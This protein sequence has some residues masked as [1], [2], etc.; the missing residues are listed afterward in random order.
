MDVQG[1]CCDAE[2]IAVEARCRGIH[3]GTFR[4]FAPTHRQIDL[5]IA[6]MLRF[7]DGLM[8]DARIY[9]DAASLHHQLGIAVDTPKSAT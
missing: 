7:R 9:Y 4:G 5:R 2:M 1:R 8:A 6:V 3:A